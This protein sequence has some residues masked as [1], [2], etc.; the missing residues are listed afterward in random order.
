MYIWHAESSIRGSIWWGI[1]KG[2][3]N[4]PTVTELWT[5]P[6]QTDP[7]DVNETSQMS[8]KPPLVD[9]PATEPS[10]SLDTGS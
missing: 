10:P 9:V 3:I 1:Y 4:S 8:V 7:I 5:P 2:I 6:N